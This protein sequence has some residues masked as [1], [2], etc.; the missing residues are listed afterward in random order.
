MKQNNFSKTALMVS[1]IRTC[2]FNESEND[3]KTNDYLANIFVFKI[4]SILSKFNKFRRLIQTKLPNGTYEWIILRTK[5]LDSIVKQVRK[6]DIKQIVIFGAGFDSRGIRQIST[7][8]NISVFEIDESFTQKI[9]LEKLKQN[10]INIPK[11][12][13]F[14][15]GDLN[16][17]SWK[18]EL[19][20][21][22]FSKNNKTLF[23]LEGV[24]MYLDEESVENVFGYIKECHK[25]NKVTFDYISK[26]SRTKDKSSEK[27]IV[28]NLNEEWL[29]EINKSDIKPFLENKNIKLIENL[30]TIELEKRFFK[31]NSNK[32]NAST[33]K[34]H[35]IVLAEV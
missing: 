3:L 35:G 5:Y 22:G 28:K 16:Q 32:T 1:L 4:F 11:H 26:Q 31:N 27:E 10:K 21:E 13:H 7:N 19:K 18:D 34:H 15:P 20:K 2:S 17:N 24:L 33:G 29:W 12:I 25:G 30:N 14:I 8:D 6:L 9:K 23:I